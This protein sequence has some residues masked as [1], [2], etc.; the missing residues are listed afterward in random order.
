MAHSFA[1]VAP[2]HDAVEARKIVHRTR[3]LGHGPIRRLM[4]PGDLGELVKPFVFL[5][6]IVHDGDGFTGPLHPHS[7]IATLTYIGE[8]AINYVDPD[9]STGRLPAGGVEWMQAGRGMWHGGGTE[10]GKLRGFQLWIALPPEL[11]L[12]P[13]RSLYQPPEDVAIAGPARVLLGTHGGVASPIDPPSAM[14]YLAVNLKSGERWTF[15]PAADQVVLWTA[16]AIGTVAT[17]S[18]LHAGEMVIFEQSGRAVEYV[19]LED[20]EFVLGAAVPHDHDLV[21]GSYSVHS[22]REALSAGEQQIREIRVKML[23]EGR[24]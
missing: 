12:G 1:E 20:S 6:L 24:V 18:E 17:P 10:P 21:L 9:Q 23:A 19:A 13:T 8:G 3:G 4:S 16:I 2:T 15:T 22:S 7:G 5:D 11:E 14:T